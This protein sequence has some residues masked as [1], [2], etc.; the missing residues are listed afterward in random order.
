MSI[1]QGVS[2]ASLPAVMALMG[3]LNGRFAPAIPSKGTVG[4]SGDLTPLAHMVLCF[5]GVGEFL[6]PD[7]RRGPAPEAL[8][9]MGLPLM[10]LSRRDGLALVN[11]TPAMTGA[12]PSG[13]AISRGRLAGAGCGQHAG[14]GRAPV[15]P[16]AHR[17]W[18][19]ERGCGGS[20]CLYLAVCAAGDRR[21][22]RYRR[23]A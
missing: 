13:P 8:A 20:G 23:L 4:A 9:D 7:G 6:L 22:A 10:D 5:Q 12:A 14:D 16:A 2:G 3:L 17:P 21:G 1:V 15:R 19:G 11:G 18:P